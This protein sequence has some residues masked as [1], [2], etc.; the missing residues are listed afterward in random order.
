MASSRETSPP[1]TRPATAATA[2]P[3]RS[4]AEADPS[5]TTAPVAATAVSTQLRTT[6]QA[7]S[8]VRDRPKH[9]QGARTPRASDRRIPALKAVSSAA[10]APRPTR[11][12]DRKG[13]ARR[14]ATAASA[15]ITTGAAHRATARSATEAANALNA[16]NASRP[17]TLLRK[18]MR[19]TTPKS[20]RMP[21]S[22]YSTLARLRHGQAAFPA[23]LRPAGKAA[24]ISIR[25]LPGVD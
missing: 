25:G 2:I 9:R 20:H 15:T 10:A 4:T 21:I 12:A 18:D 5:A 24:L 22:R 13:S 17:A 14:T 11:W 23:A 16:L 1:R 8:G 19:K 6:C 3:P 7:P